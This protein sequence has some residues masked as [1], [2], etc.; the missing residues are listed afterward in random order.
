MKQVSLPAKQGPHHHRNRFH[1]ANRCTEPTPQ[2][3]FQRFKI[4]DAL[5]RG[6]DLRFTVIQAAHRTGRDTQSTGNAALRVNDRL[7]P[8]GA[9]D[10]LGRA[11]IRVLHGIIWA[12]TPAR[13]A[14]DTSFRFDR[15]NGMPFAVNRLRR[16]NPN[17]R[18]TTLAGR[19]NP[20]C[21]TL[22]HDR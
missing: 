7:F 17:A 8:F 2:A 10:P 20:V 6:A 12:H 18:L 5:M 19:G 21:H 14:F 15:M 4:R 1:R 9:L 22:P 16:A 3:C 13:P 11:A